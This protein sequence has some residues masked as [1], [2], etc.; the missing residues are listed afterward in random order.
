M[1]AF[2]EYNKEFV[3]N[4]QY[5]KYRTSKYPDR[6]VAVVSCMDTRLTELL[7]AALGIKNGDV[8]LIK[9]AGGVIMSPFDSVMRSLLIAIYELGV[10][11]VMIVGHYDCGVQHMDGELMLH[12][13]KQRGIS[14][15]DIAFIDYCGFNVQEWLTGFSC[16]QESVQK[17]VEL[18][19]THPLIP[20][21]VVVEGFLMDPAT[22]RIDRLE[23]VCVI[24]VT[25]E[26]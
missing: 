4:R 23:E 1:D 12:H 9:N 13:M 8:K 17:S 25:K 6:N 16:V 18:V 14:E 20:N 3:S 5:E 21:D 7:P 22:G 26:K 2:L 10:N 11:E 19:R 15:Q 24:P